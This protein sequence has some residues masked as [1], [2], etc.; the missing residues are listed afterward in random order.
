MIGL[1]HFQ[2]YFS[3]RDYSVSKGLLVNFDVDT[4]HIITMQIIKF[5]LYA[6]TTPEVYGLRLAYF[7][8]GTYFICAS[9]F[10]PM[11]IVDHKNRLDGDLN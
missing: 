2:I 4:M 8:V 5:K 6:K 3:K 1:Q 10:N 11:M 7:T 9:I